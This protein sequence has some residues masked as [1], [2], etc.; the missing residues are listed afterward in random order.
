MNFS[1]IFPKH[2]PVFAKDNEKRVTSFGES[3]SQFASLLKGNLVCPRQRGFIR[4]SGIENKNFL[5][6]QVTCDMEIPNPTN[7]YLGAH[8][9]PKG[10]VVFVFSGYCISNGDIILETHP[11]VTSLGVDNLKKY[12]P[13]F[14]TEITDVSSELQ[15]FILMGNEVSKILSQRV[16]NS[17]LKNG[18]QNKDPLLNLTYVGR[19][20]YSVTCD[21]SATEDM[22][23]VFGVF[24]PVG[25]ELGDLMILR[26]G[27]SDVTDRT[28]DTFIPQMLNLDFLNYISFKKGCY[29]GQEVIARAHYRGTV[30]R[31]LRYFLCSMEKKPRVGDEIID[32][33]ERKIGTVARAA[34]GSPHNIEML[35]VMT[36]TATDF[37]DLKI[38]EQDH[39]LATELQITD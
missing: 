21:K 29:T 16:K 4:I 32:A 37:S 19:D 36:D 30:K 39:I 26:T 31:R 22:K 33:N 13:F 7:Q 11:T 17:A 12:S 3:P 15:N 25:E 2:N 6:G 20:I 8:C 23:S 5:Q 38:G 18:T 24:T 35:A 1:K 28:A 9:T 10:R 27:F 34:R 14:K